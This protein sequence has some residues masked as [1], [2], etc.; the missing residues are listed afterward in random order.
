MRTVPRVSHVVILPI[1]LALLLPAC[2]A[3]VA[4]PPSGI[5][6]SYD[7]TRIVEPLQENGDIDYVAALLP[8][9]GQGVTNENNALVLVYK[10]LGPEGLSPL[11]RE[12]APLLGVSFPTGSKSFRSFRGSDVIYK[13]ALSAPWTAEEYPEL[14]AWLTRNGWSLDMLVEASRRPRLCVPL[15]HSERRQSVLRLPLNPIRQGG[16]HALLV[17]ANKAIAHQRGG[18]AWSDLLAVYRFAELIA[19]YL[20]A[21]SR[22]ASYSLSG[23]AFAPTVAL[24]NSGNASQLRRIVL[25]FQLL[26]PHPS[27]GPL[28]DT[29]C[30]FELLD[31]IQ[32]FAHDSSLFATPYPFLPDPFMSQKDAAKVDWNVVMRITNAHFDRVVEAM[33]KETARDTRDAFS[34]IRQDRVG[35]DQR[36]KNRRGR[37]RSM[38]AAELLLSFGTTCDEDSWAF[39]EEVS[40]RRNL[41][42]LAAS[43]RCY[44]LMHGSYPN[45]LP[46]LAPDFLEELPVDGFSD[47]AFVY[48]PTQHGFVLYSLGRNGIDDTGDRRSRDADDI[49]ITFGE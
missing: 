8:R 19:Q 32:E 37:D 46:D 2:R 27:L 36:A 40:V 11:D 31:A 44:Y 38:L 25:D 6:R 28:H 34:R 41:L 4:R 10:A 7:T 23:S 9:Y 35:I 21:S 49:V 47:S 16:P 1:M 14:A 29:T 12:R 42:I 48:R 45:F 39:N 30:R 5:I 17:R 18:A 13:R 33:S 43:L 22:L 15:T 26:T 3:P 24:I 20:D